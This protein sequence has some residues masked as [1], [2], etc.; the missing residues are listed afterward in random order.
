MP[1]RIV[2]ERGNFGLLR[3]RESLPVRI[4][5]EREDTLLVGVVKERGHFGLLR[6]GDTFDC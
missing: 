6:I 5:K 3:R 2:K 4:V 1:V